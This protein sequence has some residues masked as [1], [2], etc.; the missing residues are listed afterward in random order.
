MHQRLTRH[1]RAPKHAV[2]GIG[3]LFFL[4]VLGIA[5]VEAHALEQSYVFLQ[6]NDNVVQGKFELEVTDINAALGTTFDTEQGTKLEDVGP[7]QEALERYILDKAKFS[8][9]GQALDIKITGYDLFDTSFAQFV[10]VQFDFPALVDA[11]TAIDVE[12]HLFLD[13][14]R[15]H[16]GLLV[17]TDDWKANTFN[18]ESQVSLVFGPGAREQTLDL[19]D[20]SVWR[21]F[22]G[23]VKSGIHHIAIGFDHILFLL[24][25]LFPCVVFRAE[26]RRWQPVEKASTALFNVIK[27]VTLFTV[28]HSITL[29]LSAFKILELTP[30]IVE[31]IIA[32]SIA[33]A[34]AD[35]L[36]PIFR[37]NLV[38]IVFA[39]GLFHGLGFAS[40]L[41]DI[42]IPAKY[43]PV[44]VLGFNIGVE[45]GQVAIVLV[46]FPVLFALRRTG[47]YLRLVLPAAA[48]GLIAIA[49]YWFIERALG[50]D[51]PAGAI[52]N[53]LIDALN[54]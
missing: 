14:I 19:S 8:I 24:A 44:S 32:V 30:T 25:L 22:V 48:I 38:W 36:F 40:V 18:N 41:G 49:L 43:L 6:I 37:K 28:A 10:V 12:Y 27:V 15:G 31:S 9:G 23:M 45:L 53:S 46:A 5:K 42:G 20:T 50:I 34:A 13:E 54:G 29:A 26:G 39:F 3:A 33:I 35:I 51:L 17:I 1:G 47:F 7:H 11:P 4:S 16:Q 2:L 52:L 21:G